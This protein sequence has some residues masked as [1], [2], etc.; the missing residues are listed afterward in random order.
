MSD[1]REKD[2]Q[3]VKRGLPF[4]NPNPDDVLKLY[5]AGYT[6]FIKSTSK[7]TR[8]TDGQ[9]H[10]EDG[11]FLTD[12][13]DVLGDGTDN[14]EESEDDGKMLCIYTC[15]ELLD[16]RRMVVWNLSRSAV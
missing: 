3:A 1:H 13:N 12:S 9:S 10:V 7:K 11:N 14:D 16:D 15:V 6:M 4:T 5:P 2:E 8:S